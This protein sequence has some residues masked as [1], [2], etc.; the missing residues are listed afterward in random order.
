ML[1][2]TLIRTRKWKA[3]LADL[4]AARADV[5][6]QRAEILRLLNENSRLAAKG[7]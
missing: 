6:R 5:D 3:T 7:R 1:G 2:W 4:E